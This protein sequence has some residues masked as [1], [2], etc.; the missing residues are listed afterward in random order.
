MS[1]KDESPPPPESG[2]PAPARSRGET[3]FMIVLLAATLAASI[4]FVLATT[5]GGYG[6]PSTMVAILMGVFV[7]TLAYTFLGGVRGAVFKLGGFEL[8]GAA[9]VIMIVVYAVKG[10]LGSD[11]N[12]AR[13]I[14]TGRDAEAR[15]EQE[16]ARTLAERRLKQDALRRVEELEGQAGDT[17]TN[18]VAGLVARIRASNGATPLGRGVLD[19]Y[20]R[21]VGPFNRAIRMAPLRVRFNNAISP[22]AFQYCHDRLG[23]DFAGPVLFQIVDTDAGTAAE[24]TLEGGEDIGQG[25]CSG[26]AFD[27]KLGC[28]A[29]RALFPGAAETCPNAGRVVQLNATILNADL[30]PRSSVGTRPQP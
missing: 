12:D 13:L 28:D 3:I 10:P 23:D 26:I 25:I 24:V 20:R 21:G 17:A 1:G 4:G 19:L 27:A 11:M 8:A 14:Q 22:G 7:A 5:V 9:A 2:P 29:A 16:Q 6:F 30:V 15:I 18:T